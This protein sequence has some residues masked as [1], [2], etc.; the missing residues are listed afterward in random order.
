MRRVVPGTFVASYAGGLLEHTS[1]VINLSIKSAEDYQVDRN[2]LLTGA[3]LH[4]IG[5]IE[6]YTFRPT[7][8]MTTKGRLFSQFVLGV[9]ML[10]ERLQTTG[11]RLPKED[12]YRLLHMILAH[13]GKKEWGSP[14]EPVTL[15][16]V[17]LHH[18]DYQDAQAHKYEKALNEPSPEKEWSSYQPKIGSQLFIGLC[19]EKRKIEKEEIE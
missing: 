12:Y 14:V 2:L 3:I 15:E 8:Q 1:S 11:L 10:D 18:V 9:K 5:K 6:T 16:A 13:H 7:I 17:I 4:D 19:H